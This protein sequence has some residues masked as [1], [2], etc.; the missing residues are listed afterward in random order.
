MASSKRSWE[1]EHVDGPSGQPSQEKK[2]MQVGI[3]GCG[4]ITKK[5][6]AAIEGAG[7]QVISF[8][9]QLVQP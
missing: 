7:H 2:V 8:M 4:Y 6:I 3:I 5:W 9:L 1:Y